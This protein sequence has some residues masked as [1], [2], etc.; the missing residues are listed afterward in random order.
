MTQNPGWIWTGGWNTTI[1]G[2]MS[3][4]NVA[5]IKPSQDL[6]K[7][8]IEVGPIWNNDQAVVKG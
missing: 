3:V 5:R 8:E 6:I 2:K 4:L 7:V 1:P